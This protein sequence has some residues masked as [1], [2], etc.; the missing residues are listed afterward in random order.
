MN[1]P[2]SSTVL[3]VS[4]DLPVRSERAVHSG[5]VR[6]VY[7]LGAADSA[8]LIEE[9]AYSVP[10]GSELALMV[11]SDRLSAFDCLWQSENMAGVPGKGAALNAIAAHGF[12]LFG[13]TD[14]PG[15]HLLE[16][17]HPML[18]VVRQA[19]PVMV[20]A[21]ARRYLTGSLWRAY[22]RGERVIGGEQLP[23]GLQRFDRLPELLFTPST[24][25]VMRGLAGVPE[26]DDAPI[27][28]ALLREHWAPFGFLAPEDVDRCRHAML[29]GF[30]NLAENYAAHGELLVD[31]KFEFGYVPGSAGDPELVY[32]DEVG[33]PDSSR[34][35]RLAD[36][37]RGTPKE[38]SKELFREDL[39][40]WIPDRQLL[41]DS[42]RMAE[43]LAFA[44]ANPVPD[45][46]FRKLSSVY[47]DAARRVTGGELDLPDRP[48]EAMLDLLGGEFDLLR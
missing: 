21:I 26:Y 42:E 13:G 40:N 15:H 10:P 22:E 31:S 47:V 23:D 6:S 38:Y 48:R 43:R 44:A 5:K 9:R 3:T 34:V 14:L 30:E 29:S 36:W 25:G 33:T 20:E 28:Y 12:D 4:D 32:M 1:T 17:P 7:W 45:E 11:I 37:E 27:S 16:M 46:F 39:L 8:R 24:K 41:L 2:E 18:W 35:W 19:Q